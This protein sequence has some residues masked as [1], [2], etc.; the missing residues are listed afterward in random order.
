VVARQF[1][2]RMREFE[3]MEMQYF[4]EPGTDAVAYDEWKEKRIGWHKRIG[5]REE[6]LRF[7]DHPQDKL[8]HYALAAVDVQYQFP[9]GWQEV[10]GIHNRSDFDLTQHQEFSG[11]KLDYFD[12]KNNE[13]FVPYVIETSIGLDRCTLMVL[14]DAYREEEVDG[15][16]RVVLKMHPELA[17]IQVGVF[18]LVKKPPLQEVARKIES[19]LRENFSVQYDEAGS[20]GKRYRRLDEAGTPF[21]ITVDFDTIEDDQKVTIRHRDDMSQ[22]RIPIENVSEAVRDG[23]KDWKAG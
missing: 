17:P 2:F 3:Q 23:M 18:P 19:D 1:V 15:D 21:C 7:A 10:E 11:K 6:N 13:R 8:A 9:I 20:I 5:I 12:Q 16:K 22:E 4:V 14:C